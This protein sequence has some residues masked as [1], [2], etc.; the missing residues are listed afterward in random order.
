MGA[1]VPPAPPG[2]RC[3]AAQGPRGVW[4]IRPAVTVFQQGVGGSLR[5]HPVNLDLS[6]ET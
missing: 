4:R 3:W 1:G 5:R 2:P 6:Q